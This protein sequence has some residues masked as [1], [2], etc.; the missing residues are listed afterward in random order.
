ME[1]NWIGIGKNVGTKACF[2]LGETEN[3][4]GIVSLDKRR[5]EGGKMKNSKGLI[6]YFPVACLFGQMCN[7]AHERCLRA[8][9]YWIK[10]YI[11][12]GMIHLCFRIFNFHFSI[13][14]VSSSLERS[15]K[16]KKETLRERDIYIKKITNGFLL[17]FK[18]TPRRSLL[19]P[20]SSFL[21]DLSLNF[22]K[23]KF[24]INNLIRLAECVH[25]RGSV[26]LTQPTELVVVLQL[27]LETVDLPLQFTKSER[28]RCV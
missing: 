8:T 17:L 11:E 21:Q 24:L 20:H 12:G 25:I 6:L 22:E 19:F 1:E 28:R 3:S 15:K 10:L 13:N 5:E 16:R 23:S 26:K 14:F 27:V 18:Y 4:F 7:F 9:I 2:V